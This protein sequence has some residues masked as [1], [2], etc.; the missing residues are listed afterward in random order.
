M[1]RKFVTIIAIITVSVLFLILLISSGGDAGRIHI[2]QDNGTH[3]GLP[4]WHPPMEGF[5]YQKVQATIIFSAIMMT[6]GAHLSF[7]WTSK[8]S[9]EFITYFVDGEANRTPTIEFDRLLG[10]YSAITSITGIVNF[11][12]DVGK[13]WVTVGVLHNA[14]EVTILY[15]LHQGG[16]IK[17]TTIPAWILSYIM[18]AASLSFFLDWPFDALWFK[19]QGL[20]IDYVLFI[21]FTRM[22]FDTHKGFGDETQRLVDVESTSRDHSSVE[23]DIND[24]PVGY[25]RPRY[26]LLL[27]FASFF[28]I[29]GNVYVTILLYSSHAYL[30]FVFS[31]CITFPLYTYFVYLDTHTVSI[32]P[33]QKHIVLPDSSKLSVIFVILLALFLSALTGKISVI[34]QGFH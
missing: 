3:T 22:Y 11:M 23:S 27:V 19:M 20:V 21:Q 12:V 28:H 34:Y 2:P 6:I 26:I 4:V 1:N 33:A 31:Y 18:L 14:V 5:D 10:W 32:S 16:K 15:T 7:K 24:K 9:K 29:F 17:S 13:L 30:L 8:V 25:F